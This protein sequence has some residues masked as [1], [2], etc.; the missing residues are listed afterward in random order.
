MIKTR[1]HRYVTPSEVTL[2]GFASRV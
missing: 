1:K 2:S